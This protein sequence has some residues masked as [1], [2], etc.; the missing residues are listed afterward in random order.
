MNFQKALEPIIRGIT[1]QPKHHTR[2]GILTKLEHLYNTWDSLVIETWGN[3]H[4]PDMTQR[5]RLQVKEH[6][7]TPIIIG[8]SRINGSCL[9]VK[10]E[11]LRRAGVL[12]EVMYP[13]K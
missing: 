12:L 7:L 3:K 10:S 11:F 5:L 9:D 2:A 13:G 1:S 4:P 6:P 8:M